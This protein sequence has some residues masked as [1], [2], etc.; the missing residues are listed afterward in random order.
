MNLKPLRHGIIQAF[1]RI[2]FKDIDALGILYT[3]LLIAFFFLS[4]I[5]GILNYFIIK[6]LL[7]LAL[8]VL[9]VYCIMVMSKNKNH[10]D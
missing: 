8:A 5:I 4:G 6:V 3:I 7:F 1:D 10:P 2:N 9:L